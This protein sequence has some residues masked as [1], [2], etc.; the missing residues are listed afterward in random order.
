MQCNAIQCP[1]LKGIFAPTS[2]R[3][4]R[5]F[6]CKRITILGG[7][8]IF[9]SQTD[10]S[11]N[12]DLSTSRPYNNN[13]RPHLEKINKP[14]ISPPPA[15]WVPQPGQFKKRVNAWSEM[16]LYESILL[17]SPS[18][19]S[20]K[21]MFRGNWLFWGTGDTLFFSKK[22]PGPCHMLQRRAPPLA[23]Q[24]TGRPA[25]LDLFVWWLFELLWNGLHHHHFFTDNNI[26]IIITVVN[27]IHQS[28][29]SPVAASLFFLPLVLQVKQA[30]A[31]TSTSSRRRSRRETERRRAGIWRRK[32]WKRRRRRRKSGRSISRREIK[33]TFNFK[34]TRLTAQ[35]NIVNLFIQILLSD[36]SKVTQIWS[37]ISPPLF[38]PFALSPSTVASFVAT[39]RYLA[40]ISY[41]LVHFFNHGHFLTLFYRLKSA[42]KNQNA[43]NS[44]NKWYSPQPV[45]I[46]PPSSEWDPPNRPWQTIHWENNLRSQ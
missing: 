10:A 19:Q 21:G 25:G 7:L 5:Y 44:E 13:N 4:S 35:L 43:T 17:A 41:F 42:N 18:A 3:R 1:A 2:V 6:S 30:L 27:I 34:Q 16:F 9:Y 23:A 40:F 12:E 29:P 32:R 24:Q 38:I 14:H 31:G 11:T 8:Q 37:E 46:L 15:R 36:L 20:I 33:V 26:N 28:F 22:M 39:K 45:D